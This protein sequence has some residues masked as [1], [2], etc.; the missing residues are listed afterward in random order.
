MKVDPNSISAKYGPSGLRSVIDATPAE[1][2]PPPALKPINGEGHD[3]PLPKLVPIRFVEGEKIPSRKW[4]VHGGWI[5]AR[6]A[7]LIQGDGGDGKTSLGATTPI[8][9]RD[10][11]SVAGP[12]RRRKHFDRVLHRRRR[13]R[14]QIAA[15]GHRRL[16]WAALR[17]HWQDASFSEA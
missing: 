17:Q 13:G 10:R 12:A 1:P 11:A 9:L 5:P 3:P 8:G 2:L 7:T 15:D 4:I 6:K 14:S 16:L